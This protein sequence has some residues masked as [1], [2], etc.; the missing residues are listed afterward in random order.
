MARNIGHIDEKSGLLDAS[1]YYE[2]PTSELRDANRTF[3]LP[4]KGVTVIGSNGLTCM[5]E[6]F[7]RRPLSTRRPRALGIFVAILLFSWW[8][9]FAIPSLLSFNQPE[10]DGDVSEW[11]FDEVRRIFESYAVAD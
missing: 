4:R 1:G 5:G 2:N 9:I 7:K 8:S 11:S 10:N 6:E 3:D